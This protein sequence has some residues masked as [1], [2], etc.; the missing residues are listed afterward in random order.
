MHET[1]GARGQDG[2]MRRR[3]GRG[4]TTGRAL[5]AG[6]GGVLVLGTL[7][8]ASVLGAGPAGA[9]PTTWYASPTGS[10]TTCSSA[11]PCSLTA[12][13]TSAQSGD[14]VDL[15]SG[16]YTG[17]AVTLTTSVTLQPTAAGSPVTLEGNGS[18]PVLIVNR[19]VT[20]T[21]S[22]VTI[23][24]GGGP[25]ANG[26]GILNTG[27]LVLTDAT[28][29]GNT[30]IQGTGLFNSGGTLILTDATV[31]GNTASGNGGGILNTGN[32]VLTDATVSG[33]TAGGNGG[34]IV[35]AGGVLTLT[36]A[37][38][39]GNTASGPGGIY[40]N[41][42]TAT[43]GATIIAAN[44]GGNCVGGSRITSTGYNLTD[45]TTGTACGFTQPT[46]VVDADP[47]LGP[48]ADNGGPTQT[49]LPGPGS[50]A[51][52]VIPAPTTVNGVT[53]CGGGATDQRGVPRPTGEA[54]CTIG[55]VEAAPGTS[56]S[57]TSD[58][59]TTFT[60]GDP[61][62]FPVTTTGGLPS[63]TTFSEVGT[64]PTGVT[65]NT[66]GVLSGT[67]AAGTAGYYPITITAT[68]GVT[69]AATQSFTL[70]V[71]PITPT[72]TW[73]APAAV[74]YGTALSPTQLD[75]T[76]TDP[77]NG[78]PVTG[79][80][81]YTPPLGTVLDAGTDQDLSASFVPA[82]TTLYADTS[83][84]TSITVNPATLTVSATNQTRAYGA[85][86]PTLTTTVTGFVNGDGPSVLSGA[87]A[88]STSATTTSPVGTYPITVA[89]GTLSA[90]NYTF[91]FVDGTLAV[92]QAAQAIAFTPPASG[93][94]GQ[95]ATL[96]ASGGSS[97]NPVVFTVDATSGAGVCS[98][99]GTDGTTLT[100]GA[101][102]TCV[103]DANQAG[104]EDYEA[105]PQVTGSLTVAPAS[106]PPPATTAPSFAGG[107]H[108]AVLPDG[109]GYWV[110]SPSGALSAYGS[111]P[112]LG[113]MAGQAL[114][115]P[116]VGIA[117]TPDGRGYWLVAADGGVFS[118][119]DAAFYGSTGALHLNQPVVGIASTPS[120]HGY[121]LVA[122]DGGVFS[123]GDA[124][125]SGSMGTTPLNQP[126]VAMTADPTGG[127]WLV[128]ADG[129]VFAFGDAGFYGSMAGQPLNAPI[130]GIAATPDGK[131]YWL[132]AADGGVFAFGD[133]GFYGS[134]GGGPTTDVVGL[135]STSGGSG[136]TIVRE[137]GTAR[138]F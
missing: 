48:L 87:P 95:T 33:N 93:T 16:T 79:T 92:G 130:V 94:V 70:A 122:A 1:E 75:A 54:N 131:G 136:Y 56:P 26:G 63:N 97:G 24:G 96:S 60:V 132:V 126:V 121:W 80:F 68:N 118:F 28:V 116:I 127:Y 7:S 83:G 13:L 120:G 66:A 15:D 25:G 88:L 8:L 40:T 37:T 31:S 21:V 39:S 47:Q 41:G 38:V 18:A 35:N 3:A 43:L 58:A 109:T 111:A 67:P 102:G 62:S 45:D 12:A 32:L 85:A 23:T 52:N 138:G 57:I 49:M 98:V 55:A 137:D 20:A 124:A 101:A 61:G 117:A 64:L 110:V 50:P 104:N 99:S 76:A 10:G 9:A 46:D 113:S 86:N 84:S 6:C 78:E 53:V 69:P 14:T 44:T 65:L 71:G 128:A 125:F 108:L 72:I 112:N 30:A 19:S 74:T 42:G 100:Y 73:T 133:A 36:D 2:T 4:R 134:E 77:T 82:D 105:A 123:F 29:S 34:G 135:F 5:R 89:Q 107:A 119:G 22:G 81:T 11:S 115:A 27:N 91:A 17:T 51:A 103:L 114:N 90:A 129:G 106:T 59:T